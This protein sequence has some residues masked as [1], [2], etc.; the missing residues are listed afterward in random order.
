M[1]PCQTF[2]IISFKQRPREETDKSFHHRVIIIPQPGVMFVSDAASYQT[3]TH[4]AYVGAKEV[5]VIGL[6]PLFPDE[7]KKRKNR[8]KIEYGLFDIFE[9]YSHI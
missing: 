7:E 2:C 9:K 3:E 8:E 4:T 6:T 5:T 1:A